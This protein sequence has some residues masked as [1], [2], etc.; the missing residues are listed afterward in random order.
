MSTGV[1]AAASIRYATTISAATS[2]VYPYRPEGSKITAPGLLPA[3]GRNGDPATWASVPCVGSMAR[4]PI[5]GCATLAS[6]LAIATYR[7]RG[8]IVIP[9]AVLPPLKYGEPA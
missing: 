5:V 2:L 4:T 6:T 9:I 1:P 3:A 8:S 7:D